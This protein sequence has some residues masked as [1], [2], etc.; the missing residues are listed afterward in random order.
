MLLDTVLFDMGGTVEDISF[1]SETVES[2]TKQLMEILNA[3]GVPVNCN[4]VV[5]WNRINCGIRNYK[6]WSQNAMLEKKPEEIW[7][8]FYL[9]DF[10]FPRE[11]IV[12]LSETLAQTWESV[13]FHRELRPNVRETLEALR[14]RGYKLGVISNTASLYS[15]FNVLEEYGIRQYFGDV[16]LSSVT[17]YRKP[18]PGIFTIALRQMCSE[19]ENCIYVGDTMSRDIIGSKKAHFAKAVQIRSFMTDIS[20]AQV[21]DSRYQPDHI[22]YDLSELVEYLDRLREEEQKNIG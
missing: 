10:D 21:G 11:R 3:N 6:G 12:Q 15:V 2:V 4:S 18:H 20:D 22:I 16:T 8:D 5:F 19:P 14:Q 7:P 17:G 9:S 13:Y 1:N